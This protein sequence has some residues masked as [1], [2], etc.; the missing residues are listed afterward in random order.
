MG[1]D[2]CWMK[3]MLKVQGFAERSGTWPEVAPLMTK[4]RGGNNDMLKYRRFQ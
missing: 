3:A 1:V 2:G 4:E